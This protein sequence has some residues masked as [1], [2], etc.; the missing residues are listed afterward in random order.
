VRL[1]VNT[2]RPPLDQRAVRQALLYALDRA[3][4][5]EVVT[6]APPVLGSPGIVPPETPWFRPALPAYAFDPERARAL[7]GGS[8]VT[9]ELLADPSYREPELMQPMLQAVGITLDVKR[10]D[11]KTRTQ[12]LR[13]GNF[14][15]AEVQHLGVGGDPDFLRRWSDGVEANDFAQGWTFDN[16]EFSRLAHDQAATIDPT[17]RREL[18]FRMQAILA[19]ELPTIPLYYRRFYWAYD[20]HN[21]TPMNTAGGLM[22]GL[23]MVH[24]KLIFLQR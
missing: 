18:V 6:R 13:E 23:P 3:R 14:A 20:T 9:L 1:A 15:L 5:A 24:N 22:N 19:D 17:R 8:S 2:S 12:L 10:V 7:L 11:P 21:V 4:I 16:A